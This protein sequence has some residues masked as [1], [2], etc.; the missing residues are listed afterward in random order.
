VLSDLAQTGDLLPD[1]RWLLGGGGR[2][3]GR[4]RRGGVGAL[5]RD[6]LDVGLHDPEHRDRELQQHAHVD[7]VQENPSGATTS[8]TKTPA[9]A[10]EMNAATTSTSAPRPSA[11]S[12]GRR[13]VG[14]HG[15]GEW[16]IY[17]YAPAGR[18]LGYGTARARAFGSNGAILYV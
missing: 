5:E 16:W 10:L 9:A 12:D 2:R 14:R 18:L 8:S 11:I 7:R 4:R 15:D 13:V 6:E 1:G 3:R 17:V